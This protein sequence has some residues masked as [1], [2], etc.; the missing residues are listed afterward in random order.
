MTKISGGC[1]CGKVQYEI[2]GPLFGA[3]NCHCSMCRR[4]HGA[5]FASYAAFNPLHFSW[6]S[7][8]SLVKTYETAKGFGWCFCSECGSTLAASIKG[9]VSY[10]TLGSV[11]GDPG[12]KPELHIFVGSK[13]D[14]FDIT[15]ALPQYHERP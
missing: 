12:V 13:A 10:V 5:A 4:Q 15:D 9:Q 1:L 8:A 3:D 7:G 2:A 6:V 14:W 11:K